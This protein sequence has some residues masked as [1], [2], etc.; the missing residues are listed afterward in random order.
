MIKEMKVPTL[1]EIL[2]IEDKVRFKFLYRNKLYKN[3]IAKSC[4]YTII[5]NKLLFADDIP[6]V[7]SCLFLN[8]LYDEDLI[9]IETIDE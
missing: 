3:R 2:G 5:N 4:T 6:Y 8:Q 1:N 9:G 7:L